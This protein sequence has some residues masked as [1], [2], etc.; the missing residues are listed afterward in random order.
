MIRTTLLT[1][2]AAGLALTPLAPGAEIHVPGD[3]STIQAA[4]NAAAQFNDE[5]IVGPGTYVE[6]I[7]MLGKA[8]TLRS[9][10]GPQSTVIDGGG[11]NTVIRCVTDESFATV[12]D[13]FLIA[14]GDSTGSTA[15]AGMFNV[16]SS[17]TVM[18]CI[19]TNNV[20][21]DGGGMYNFGANPTVTN[22]LFVGNAATSFAGRGGGMYNSFSN[23]LIINTTF[24][25]NLG[26][27]GGGIHSATG[28]ARLFNCIVWGN[29]VD[30][31]GGPDLP[32]V[33]H[34]DVPA[35][36]AGEG[37]ISAD[38]QFTDPEEGEYALL[39]TSPCID[40]GD[41]T[42]IAENFFYDLAGNLRGR[43]DPA[44]TDRGIAVF[45]ITVDMGPYEFQPEGTGGGSCPGDLDGDGSVA[46]QDL[47]Q[48]LF[49]WGPCP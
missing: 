39:P 43:D 30:D 20:A 44:T 1:A 8:V 35:T 49:D 38:P 32:V 29:T 25:N 17:P 18:N 5:I 26:N 41:S 48:L 23:P 7:D 4:I 14:N 12:I 9:S 36:I 16:L 40:R 45:A 3:H 13:G 47:V 15:G 10:D 46:F 33:T 22:C 24:T 42:V 37:N 11:V 31:F 34:S 28:L 19:F 21:D 2:A 27:S 6:N